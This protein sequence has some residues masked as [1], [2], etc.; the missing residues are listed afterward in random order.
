MNAEVGLANAKA[1][2]DSG[3]INHG[4]TYMNIDDSW[5]GKRGGPFHAIQGNEKFPD[6]KALCDGVHS[7]GLKIGIY[8]TPWT[9]SYATHIGGSAENPE[10]TWEKLTG[11]KVVNKKTLP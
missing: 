7:L 11:K 8:S 6:M 4:W 10:G 9:P 1:V 3:L 2:A 5:Q